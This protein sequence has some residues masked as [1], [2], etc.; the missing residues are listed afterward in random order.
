VRQDGPL[1]AG[2]DHQPDPVAVDPG[3]DDQ[4]ALLHGQGHLRDH[5]QLAV[6]DAPRAAGEEKQG[7]ARQPGPP[8]GPPDTRF[9]QRIYC[10][11]TWTAACTA[12]PS[13]SSMVI[14]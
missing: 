8:A 10:P 2:I 13:E 11:L 5:G 3:R 7:K 9:A 14:L 1:S 6:L 12:A 4:Q